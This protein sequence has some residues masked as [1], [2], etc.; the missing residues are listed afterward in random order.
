MEWN[1]WIIFDFKWLK[2]VDNAIYIDQ[3]VKGVVEHGRVKGGG[4]GFNQ[5]FFFLK[6]LTNGCLR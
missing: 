6:F 4:G 3:Q 2:T 1:T 5:N